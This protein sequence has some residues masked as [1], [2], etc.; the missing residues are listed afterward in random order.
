MDAVSALRQCPNGASVSE[1][2]DASVTDAILLQP[3]IMELRQRP[4]DIQYHQLY[5]ISDPHSWR[6][7][8]SPH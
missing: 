6:T 8:L 3:E 5:T 1:R 4:T 2:S 7:N